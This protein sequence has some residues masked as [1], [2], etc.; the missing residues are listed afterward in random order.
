MSMR[1]KA[2]LLAMITAPLGAQVPAAPAPVPIVPASPADSLQPITL[3]AAVAAAQ[4]NSPAAVQARGSITTSES[5]VRSAYGAFLPD[6][7]F[8]LGTNK[9]NGQRQG[10]TGELVDYRANQSYSVGFASSITLFDGTRFA[11][12]SSARANVTAA[13]ASEVASR[14]RIALDVKTAYYNALAARESESA[15][16]AEL[17][18]AEQQ[19]RAAAAR[20]RAGSATRSDSLRSIIAVGNARLAV[21]TAQNEIRTASALLTRLVASPVPV[22]PVASD[23][24]ERVDFAP[25]DTTTIVALAAN[26]PAVEQARAQYAAARAVTR[27]AKGGY[28]P[29]VGLNFRRNGSGFDPRFGFGDDQLAYSNTWSIGLSLPVFNNF[30]REDQLTRARVQEEIAEANLRDAQLLS[31]QNFVQQLGVLRTAEARV[32]IQQAS[33]A[34]AEEDVRVQQQRY[35][36]GAST[37][38]DLLTSQSALNQ[39]RSA[40]IQA[41]LDYRISRAQIEAII[42]QELP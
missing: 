30:A 24:L 25:L 10:P 20:V 26:G 18:Q 36:L 2:A 31:R 42:G 9:S 16:R 28:L 38:L 41:R 27:G 11:N 3:D 33:V 34:A 15:A 7:N 23:T 39:A 1:Y 32:Q 22:T 29:T 35:N 21:L 40:L 13:E 12:L 8:N 37:L 19:L 14:Y 17:E 5:G 4:A 6:F